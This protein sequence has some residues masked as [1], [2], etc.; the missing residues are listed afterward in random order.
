MTM[1][2]GDFEKENRNTRR[3]KSILC[4]ENLQPCW[5]LQFFFIPIESEK[6][7]TTI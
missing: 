5:L 3:S 2:F 4:E 7:K 6:V 1:C